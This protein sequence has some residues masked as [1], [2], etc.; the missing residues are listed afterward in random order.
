MLFIQFLRQSQIRSLGHNTL[1]VKHGD[2]TQWLLD[3]QDT[4]LQVET[5]IDEG[6][7]D[8]FASILFLFQDE[9]VMVEELL[10]LLIDKVNPELFE[11]VE[12][13]DFETGNVE[14]TDEVV[15]RETFLVEG[16]VT[17][18]DDPVED[19]G[20]QGFGHGTDSPADLFKILA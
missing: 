17:F 20:I 8:A 12:V 6:P 11:W 13:E 10:E 16:H 18:G 4:G 1:F 19:T 3:K 5:E 9:H 15:T 7:L 14:H 2:D